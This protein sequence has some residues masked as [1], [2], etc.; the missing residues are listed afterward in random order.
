M[1]GKTS[2]ASGLFL[3]FFTSDNFG[4]A[5]AGFGCFRAL[6][7]VHA[8]LLLRVWR[9]DFAAALAILDKP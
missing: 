6:T 3:Q 2:K 8:K 4:R 7:Y 5:V 9:K 1:A